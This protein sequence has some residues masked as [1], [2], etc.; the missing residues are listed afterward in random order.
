MKKT[1]RLY[2]WGYQ[3]H[4]AWSVAYLAEKV[5][6]ELGVSLKPDILIVGILRSG[7]E[8][9]HPV[10]VEPE[11]GKW[12]LSLFSEIPTRYPETIK[13]HPL[14]NMFY[15]DAPS[16]EEKPENIRRSS[17]SIVVQEALNEFDRQNDVRSFC[18]S[19]RPIGSYYVVPVIQIPGAIFWQFPPLNLP[20]TED[21]FQPKGEHSLIHSALGTLLDE[22]SHDLLGPDP[23]RST[24]S[25][26][27]SAS[28]IVG[29]AAERFMRIPDLLTAQRRYGSGDLFQ[30]LNILSSLF[31]EGREGLGSMILARPDSLFLRYSVRFRTPVPLRE[32]RWARKILQMASTE[33]ALICSEGLIHGLGGIAA[34]HHPDALDA[35]TVNFLDHYQ[36]ELCLGERALMY[37]RYREPKLPQ[38]PVSYERFVSNYVRLFS[39]A[40]ASDAEVIWELF[41]ACTAM[42]HGSM[43]V[44]AEDAEAEAQR[45]SDQGTPIHPVHMDYELLHRVSGIDGSILLDPKGI[46]Y[47]IGVI[48]DGSATSDCS[49]ARGSRFNSALRYVGRAPVARL[50]IVVSDD[51]TIDL[52]PLLRPQIRKREIEERIA[53]LEKALTDNY[54][55]AQNWLNEH[56]FYLDEA[57]CERINEALHRLEQLPRNVGEIRYIT[58]P[59]F[60]NKELDE[61]YFL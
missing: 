13:T 17:A 56:R 22:A 8:D 18:G 46:C 39:S 33:I 53:Q 42:T 5:F 54:H 16:M 45:L 41:K 59:F 30:R 58:S 28:E 27:R 34:D 37:S 12:P 23:G 43:L 36:W 1:I 57:Q 21:Q 51:K 6:A 24:T 20:D 29:E 3:E 19:A 40:S 2:M 14:Q 32:P 61:T 47:A 60:P 49:P 9:Q 55:A 11:D 26:M 7:E 52:I 31:Y 38:G 25:T 48:L 15:G 10:C 44:V 35:F 4:F 50:A